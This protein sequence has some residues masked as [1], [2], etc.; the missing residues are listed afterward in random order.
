M[1]ISV[2]QGHNLLL[3]GRSG[4]IQRSDE[5]YISYF[6]IR[7]PRL[8]R[9]GSTTRTLTGGLDQSVTLVGKQSLKEFSLELRA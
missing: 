4:I 9:V 7:N 2:G 1:C 5:L 3:I 6:P 8:D